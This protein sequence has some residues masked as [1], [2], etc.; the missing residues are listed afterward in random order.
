[1]SEQIEEFAGQQLLAMDPRSEK[2]VRNCPACDSSRASEVGIKNELDIVRCNECGSLYTPYSPWYS[3]ARYYFD[4]YNPRNPVEPAWVVKRL[5][6][7]TADF[8]SYRQTNRLLD[9]G[10]GAGTLLNV[11]RAGGWNAQGVDVSESAAEHVR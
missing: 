3:S 9:V 8:S 11:A 10:C 4:Y 5:E 7:I 2:T 1:M 6:E